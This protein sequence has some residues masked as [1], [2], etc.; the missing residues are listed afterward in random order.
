MLG[1]SRYDSAWLGAVAGS[2]P[3]LDLVGAGVGAGDH[4]LDA[5]DGRLGKGLAE[6]LDLARA[7]LPIAAGHA[8]DGAVVLGDEE[9]A[10]GLGLEVGEVAVLVEDARQLGHLG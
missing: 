8:E 1:A 6:E 4:V 5:F 2:L 10:V 7:G 9:G 3:G